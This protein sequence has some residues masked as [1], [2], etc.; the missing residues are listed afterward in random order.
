MLREIYDYFNNPRIFFGN[1]TTTVTPSAT[2]NIGAG[3]L[4]L[5]RGGAGLFTTTRKQPFTRLGMVFGSNYTLNGGYCDLSAA[6]TAILDNLRLNDQTGAAADGTV[7]ILSVGYNSSDVSICSRQQVACSRRRSRIICAR[8]TG[9]TP[10]L[11]FGLTDFTLNKTGTGVYALTFKRAFASTPAVFATAVLNSGNRGVIVSARTAS[12]CILSVHNQAGT[13]TDAVLHIVVIGSDSRDEHGGAFS[14]I[15]NPQR[16]PRIVA[17]SVT[18][19]AGTYSL[20]VNSQAFTG[21]VK[22]GT[23]DITVTLSKPFRQQPVCL[24]SAAGTRAQLVTVDSSTI[25]LIGLAGGAVT[26][27]DPTVFNI[28]AIGSDDSTEF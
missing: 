15:Q 7:D 28:L 2:V 17:G 5:A 20:G 24:L 14:R 12:G 25:R 13:A 27:T 9:A 22:N 11:D 10:S 6:S 4:T 16:K 8:I 21:V 26:A 3:D 23:G 19:S 1:L 18:Q